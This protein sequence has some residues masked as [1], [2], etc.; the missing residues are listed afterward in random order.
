M[1]TLFTALIA[2]AC[3]SSAALMG[4][5]WHRFRRTLPVHAHVWIPFILFFLSVGVGALSVS[6]GWA[7]WHLLTVRGSLALTGWMLF[8]SLLRM[9]PHLKAHE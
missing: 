7:G 3:L 1:D 5:Y 6:F 9:I 4:Y 2:S 8:V